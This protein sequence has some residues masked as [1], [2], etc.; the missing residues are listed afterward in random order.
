MERSADNR[1]RTTEWEDVQYKY[2]NRVGKYETHELEILA[3]KMADKNQ[4]TCLVAYDPHAERVADK[5]ERGGYEVEEG[6]TED[7]AAIDDSDDDDDA[8]AAIRKRRMAELQ[9]QK[10]NERFGVLRHVAGAD[11]VTEVTEASA[12]CWVVAVLIRPG[13]SDCEAL[14]TVLRTVAQRHRTIKFVS[15]IST[16][17]IPNFP[18]RHLPCVLLYHNKELKKQVTNLEEWMEKKQLNVG[19]AERL[20]SRYGVL[21]RNEDD[22]ETDRNEGEENN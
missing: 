4:N 16:D 5:L 13:H 7:A 11:Y 1:I 18:D 21:P 10:A 6:G 3:Q 15:M 9:R 8:L 20:L 22:D 19:T 12:A 2:G 17:A 14:L